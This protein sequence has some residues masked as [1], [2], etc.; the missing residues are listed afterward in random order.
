MLIAELK[1]H[2]SIASITLKPYTIEIKH[3][4]DKGVISRL[5][6]FEA[7]VNCLTIKLKNHIGTM[8]KTILESLKED[9]LI[10]G[11]GSANTNIRAQISGTVLEIPVREGDQVIRK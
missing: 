9:L 2:N 11:G 1:R 10:G 4:F 5:Q 6:D 3:L 7:I 8:L